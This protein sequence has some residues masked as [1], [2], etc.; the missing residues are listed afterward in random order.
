MSR[1]IHFLARLYPRSWRQRY[2]AEYAALLEDVRPDG[3]TA[4]DVIAG[5]LAMHIRNWKS[6][7]ILAG[8]ALCGAAVIVGLFVA[9]PNS[10]VSVAVLKV[11]GQAGGRETI[12]AI[13]SMME[14]VE[15]RAELTG[16]ITA[17]GLYLSRRS[18][19]PFEDV[20][21]E[22]KKNIT[23]QPLGANVAA[24]KIQFNYS[25]PHLAQQVTQGL[26]ARFLDENFRPH[27]VTLQILDAASL[28]QS[29]FYPNKPLIIGVGVA[30]FL[31]MWGGLSA[32]RSVSARRY[33]GAGSSISLPGSPGGGAAEL[34]MP[35]IREHVRRKTWKILAAIAL[36]IAVGALAFR[37]ANPNLYES[38]AVMRVDAPTG[39]N[40]ANPLDGVR[41]L[42]SLTAS[43]ESRS[44]LV[45]I[46]DDEKL[47][48]SER[49]RMPLEDV[50]EK[51]KKSIRLEPLGSTTGVVRIGFTYTDPYAAE[52]AT[53]ALVL[54]FVD[55]S[56]VGNAAAAITVID[57]ADFPQPRLFSVERPSFAAGLFFGLPLGV[58]LA[59]IVALFRR[60]P[61]PV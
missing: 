58:I 54:R 1:M 61:A 31:L 20:I 10:Y 29:P 39:Q 14:S 43:V 12:D 60:S 15:S 17:G 4:V 24:F 56:S 7:G 34:T 19:M 48:L 38:R 6:W 26:V 27:G 59:V 23:I 42:I 52:R 21:E 11:E 16:L 49:S 44:S 13:N 18:R 25:D 9:M 50:I 53:Q 45:R 51:M 28:P 22:M 3:R 33:A 40:Q 2:G 57:N 30:C 36:L 47:Y 8:S 41:Y 46:I 37:L 32:W 35:P 55:A 5:A